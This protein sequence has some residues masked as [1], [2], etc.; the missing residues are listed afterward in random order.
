MYLSD[1]FPRDFISIDLNAGI[2]A[3][4]IRVSAFHERV[5]LAS[6]ILSTTLS[7]VQAF[8]MRWRLR[9]DTSSTKCGTMNFALLPVGEQEIVF[10]GDRA[11]S[12][13]CEYKYL[14][15]V[16]DRKLTFRSHIDRVRRRAWAAFHQLRNMFFFD[17]QVEE[18][19]AVYRRRG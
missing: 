11:L 15:I 12:S 8:G 10:F 6:S 3:D 5:S 17:P 14:G 9:F 18:E 7:D 2:F 13:F 16:F 4:D 1:L 19:P